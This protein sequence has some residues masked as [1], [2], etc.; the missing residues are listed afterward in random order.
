MSD[1][2]RKLG[3]SDEDYRDYLELSNHRCW[4]CG[5]PE[6]VADRRLAVDHCHETDAIRGLLCTRCNRSLGSIGDRRECA[7][8]LRRAADYL[9]ASWRCFGD[10]CDR[11]HEGYGPHAVVRRDGTATLFEYRCPPCRFTWTCTWKTHGVPLS[12]EMSGVPVPEICI[13]EDL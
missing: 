2:R 1:T 9:E 10:C 12:W 6:S 4:L 7:S 5:E 11:C 8:W 13:E 3:L